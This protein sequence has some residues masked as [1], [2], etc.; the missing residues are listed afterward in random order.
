MLNF[1]AVEAQAPLII[2]TGK[3]HK[4]PGAWMNDTPSATV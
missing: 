1:C 2:M 3:N 4:P